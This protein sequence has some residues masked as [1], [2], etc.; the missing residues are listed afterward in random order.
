MESDSELEQKIAVVCVRIQVMVNA[1]TSRLVS[2]DCCSDACTMKVTG[3]G[4]SQVCKMKLI[5]VDSHLDARK[6]YVF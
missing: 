2:K 4:K 3:K 5:L 6:K 1:V